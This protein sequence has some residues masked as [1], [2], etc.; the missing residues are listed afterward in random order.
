MNEIL[1]ADLKKVCGVPQS[2]ISETAAGLGYTRGNE[3]R[4]LRKLTL[5]EAIRIAVTRELMALGLLA[6]AALDI[7]RQLKEETILDIV[8]KDKRAWL[9]VR[10]DPDGPAEYAFTIA[11][12]KEAVEITMGQPDDVIAQVT[13]GEQPRTF[14]IVDLHKLARAVVIAATERREREATRARE[15][16]TL[17]PYQTK[18]EIHGA[19]VEDLGPD[20]GLALVRYGKGERLRM[21]AAEARALAEKLLSMAAEREGSTPEKLN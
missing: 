2:R 6:V 3:G 9:L 17:S 10:R 5:G 4:R 1:I 19:V 13:N 16:T 14:R 12:L 21:S 11:S 7:G 18:P 8:A 15:G 20:I